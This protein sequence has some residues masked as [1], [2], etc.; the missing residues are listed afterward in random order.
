MWPWLN[1]IILSWFPSDYRLD[2]GD[3]C[4][5]P[6]YSDGCDGQVCARAFIP[7]LVLARANLGGK[8]SGGGRNQ[9]IQKEPGFF[10]PREG[11][12]QALTCVYAILRYYTV[13]GE[14]KPESGLWT[15]DAGLWTLDFGL[16]TLDIGLGTLDLQVT[17]DE[18]E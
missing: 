10:A 13:P 12:V 16:G 11:N 6:G 15:R 17:G 8:R 18:Y 4:H 1:N 2:K 5:Y 14:R 3:I 7:C 9:V